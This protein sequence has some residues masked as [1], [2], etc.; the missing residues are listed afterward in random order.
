M[1]KSMDSLVVLYCDDLNN[2]VFDGLLIIFSSLFLTHETG[3][4]SLITM[5]HDWLVMLTEEVKFY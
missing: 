4:P 5:T 3:K 2:E 1:M